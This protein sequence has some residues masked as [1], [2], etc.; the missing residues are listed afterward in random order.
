SDRHSAVRDDDQGES[1]DRDATPEEERDR[2]ETRTRV[3]AEIPPRRWLHGIRPPVG[4]GDRRRRPS[5]GL[6]ARGAAGR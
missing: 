4:E 3:G 1:G 6:R 5:L 2:A